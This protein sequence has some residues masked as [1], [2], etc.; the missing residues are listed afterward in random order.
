MLFCGLRKSEVIGLKW[1]AADL[2]N[3][4]FTIQSTVVKFKTQIEKETTKT[5]SSHRTYLLPDSM[6]NLPASVKVRHVRFH[7][8]RH[9]T[10]SL[11]LN[12]GYD[13]KRIPEWPGHSDIS[14]AGKGSDFSRNERN[15]VSI[16][17][18]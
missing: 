7:D 6:F 5:K 18:N 3:R 1:E 14:T 10:A 11:L 12:A 8:L 2:E 17:G 15:S 4:C 13:L 16:E 9:T